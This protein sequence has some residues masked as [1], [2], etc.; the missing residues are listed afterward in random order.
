MTISLIFS[1]TVFL[2]IAAITPGPNNLL[3][4]SSGANVGFKGSLRLMAGIMLGMQCV[5]LSSAFGVAALLIIYPALHIGLKIVGSAYL[6]WLAWKTATSSYQRLDIPAKTSQ[7][8]SGFQGGLLQFLNPKAWMM[9]LGAVGSFSLSG[10]AYFGSVIAISVI[11]VIV[12]F[13]AGIVWI[14]GGTLI[15]LFLQSR[16]SWFIF[17]ISMGLLTALCVPLIWIG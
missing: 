8:V 6:L 4:T 10:D 2:F 12:N 5:L 13:V 11:M 1:L 16:R 3:L 17:N 7:A 14:L 9:G 15:S